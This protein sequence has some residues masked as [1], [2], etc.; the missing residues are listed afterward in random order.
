MSYDGLM[1]HLIYA[2]QFKGTAAPGLEAGTMKVT[3]SATSCSI[4][5]VV[6]ADGIEGTFQPAEGGMA[7]FESEARMI[8]PDTFTETGTIS[9]GE[10]DSTLT[11]ST[12]LQ[13]HLDSKAGTGAVMWKIDSG[14]G[15]FAGATGNITSNFFLAADGTV[16]DYHFGVI[17]MK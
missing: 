10:G 1:K 14:E 7:F 11:F 8:G 9:F 4:R 2:M 16:T 15:Q 17:Y 13:G 6:G 12:I 3:T 5:S